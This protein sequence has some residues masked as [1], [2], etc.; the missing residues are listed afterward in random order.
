MGSGQP[1]T[2]PG[3][4]REVPRHAALGGAAILEQQET[5]PAVLRTAAASEEADLSLSRRFFNP[6]TLIGLA[7]AAAIIVFLLT[8]FDIDLGATWAEIRASD[9]WLLAAAVVTFYLSFPLRGVRWLALM[10]N[11]NL[12]TDRGVSLPPLRQVVLIVLLGWFANCLVPARLGDAYRAYLVKRGAGVSFS[13]TVGTILAER[14]ID[15][16]VLFSLLLAAAI[17]V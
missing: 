1:A 10:S 6:H 11:V 3:P 4:T 7:A 9:P 13:R 16:V 8:R 2:G 14:V 12:G 5:T 17:W 15:V